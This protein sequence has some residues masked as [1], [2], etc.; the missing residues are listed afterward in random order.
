[1][2]PYTL[3]L[4]KAVYAG[5]GAM[6]KLEGVLK[7]A[8]ATKGSLCIDKSILRAGLAD[9]AVEIIKSLGLGVEVCSDLAIE[10]TYA[11]VQKTVDWFCESGCIRVAAIG[12]ALSWI[13]SSWCV[14]ARLSTAS[15]LL[16]DHYHRKQ[17]K[18]VMV[19]TTAGTG[20][21]AIFSAVVC[22][23]R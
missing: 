2:S 15:W 3:K 14:L 1:M 13:A 12:D 18:T 22:I 10:R 21:E 16:G 5:K 7:E 6:S 4:P 8:G 19:P 11:E 20:A 9:G 17:V 23:P